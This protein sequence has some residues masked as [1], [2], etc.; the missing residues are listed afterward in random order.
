MEEKNTNQPD[1]GQVHF[2][3][4]FIEFP[5][6]ERTRRWYTIWVA[7]IALILLFSLLTANFLFALIILMAAMTFSLFHRTKGEVDFKITED[8][9][10]V[11]DRF[12]EYKDLKN[13]FIIYE[14][15]HIKTLYFEPKSLLNPRIPV[16][17]EDQNPV[18]VRDVLKQYLEEDLDREYEPIT[19]QVSRMFKL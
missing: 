8:G 5:N 19:D 9:I 4:K 13:F 14:P 3:W 18:Q 2:S 6:Y 15:P 7:V 12:F 17:L 11:N 16:N 1:Y 10:L